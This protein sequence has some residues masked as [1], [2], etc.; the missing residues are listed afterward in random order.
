MLDNAVNKCKIES[1]P[2]SDYRHIVSVLD[3]ILALSPKS[4]LDIGIG[5][6]KMGV[7]LREY[8]DIWNGRYER[9]K[10]TTKIYGIEVFEKYHNPIYDYIYDRVLIG[11]AIELV[12][13]FSDI[14]LIIMMDVLEHLDKDSGL[15][16]IDKCINISK[17]VLI[18]TPKEFFI[19]DYSHN[20]YEKHQS[21]WTVDDFSKYSYLYE[22][23]QATF[24][25]II[26]KPNGKPEHRF[27]L[28]P[29]E[30]EPLK[31]ILA[32]IFKKFLKKMKRDL[33]HKE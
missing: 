11:N 31:R 25:C 13:N 27:V 12:E 30:R 22:E 10:W 20:I 14:D 28:S 8:L 18:T 3:H 16:L 17:A 26:K 5:F 15:A 4:I 23:A 7:L 21:L 33:L 9:E 19:N 32:I 24:I 6:G 29:M 2:T 1:V